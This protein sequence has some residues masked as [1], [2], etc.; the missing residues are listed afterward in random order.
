MTGL[1]LLRA[2]ADENLEPILRLAVR[3]WLL[4]ELWPILALLSTERPV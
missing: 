4:P 1:V 3:V 2:L